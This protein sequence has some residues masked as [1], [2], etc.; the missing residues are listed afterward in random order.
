[1]EGSRSGAGSVQ[2]ITDP[3]LNPRGLEE[4]MVYNFLV[5]GRIRIR[6]IRI[7]VLGVQKHTDPRDPDPEHW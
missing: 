4:I 1:M 7:Q 3:D 6:Q 2:I 5:A